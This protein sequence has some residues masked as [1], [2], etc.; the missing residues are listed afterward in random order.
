MSEDQWMEQM[1]TDEKLKLLI[2]E[3]EPDMRLA[4]SEE[5]RILKFEQV[6]A[7]NAEEASKI[8]ANDK[9]IIAVLSDYAMPGMNGL[10]FLRH[11]RESG[12]EMP[13]V[14]L[15][16]HPEK[17]VLTEAIRLGAMDFLEKPCPPQELIPTL[18]QALRLGMF[19]RATQG[20]FDR[21]ADKYSIS[22][23]DRDR[24]RAF[25][26]ASLSGRR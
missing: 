8:L 12:F 16:G 19:M 21:L 1:M 18:R 10:E 6:V 22:E 14:F 17:E 26:R 9:Q 2:V 15:S 4:L 11:A 23:S 7:N 24:F 5:L 25:Q 3:D 20:E 13:F